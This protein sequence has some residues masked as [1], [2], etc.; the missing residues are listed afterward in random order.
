MRGGD[1]LVLPLR[2]ST[3]LISPPLISRVVR[4][5]CQLAL[6]EEKI[7][8]SVRENELPTTYN[9]HEIENFVEWHTEWSVQRMSSSCIQ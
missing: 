9:L 1:E 2:G 6:L 5:L 7:R 8:L 3:V 4:E